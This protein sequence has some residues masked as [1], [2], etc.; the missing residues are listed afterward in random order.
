VTW[1]ALQT[2]EMPEQWSSGTRDHTADATH[3][4]PAKPSPAAETAFYRR[5]AERTARLM[6]KPAPKWKVCPG[7]KLAFHGPD[8]LPE[9]RATGHTPGDWQP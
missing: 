7:C 6:G 5:A 4:V 3:L 1:F 2:G 9:N 8:T